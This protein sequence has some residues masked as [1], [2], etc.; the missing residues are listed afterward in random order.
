MAPDCRAM[1]VQADLP[2]LRTPYAAALGAG[3]GVNGRF[4]QSPLEDDPALVDLN[5]RSTVHLAKAPDPSDGGGA[6]GRLLV[7]SSIA[8]VV[9]GPLHATYAA[10]KAFVPR[11]SRAFASS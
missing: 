1:A 4:D 10:S 3:I 2:L 9:P 11:S 5:V 8:A 6:D 7:T